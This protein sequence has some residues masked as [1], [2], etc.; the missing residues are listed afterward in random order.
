MSYIKYER[1][2]KQQFNE[3]ADRLRVQTAVVEGGD[4]AHPEIKWGTALA[5]GLAEVFA[6]GVSYQAFLNL[7]PKDFDN[8]S[9]D[10]FQGMQKLLDYLETGKAVI[11]LEHDEVKFVTASSSEAIKIQLRNT[12]TFIA[13]EADVAAPNRQVNM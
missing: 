12:P 13:T 5:R 3:L 1:P 4:G 6:P 7:L 2:T 9:L 10:L 11:K 8:T